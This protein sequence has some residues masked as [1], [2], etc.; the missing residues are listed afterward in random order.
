MVLLKTLNFWRPN[1]APKVLLGIILFGT[2]A[3]STSDVSR[4]TSISVGTGSPEFLSQTLDTE[5][6]ALLGVSQPSGSGL[7]SFR[8]SYKL[9]ANYGVSLRHSVSTGLSQKSKLRGSISGE[10]G[11][12]GYHLPDGV[13]LANGITRLTDPID[14][15]FEYIGLRPEIEVSRDVSLG[16][17]NVQFG[18]GAGYSMQSV[19]IK[20][21]S[22][23]LDFSRHRWSHTP[24]LLLSSRVPLRNESSEFEVYYR[25]SSAD[26][27][28][29][30]A[31]YT[32]SF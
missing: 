3:C 16:N 14:L 26:S 5:E 6:D 11:K 17:L 21:R 7:S 20:A 24:Y 18:V 25:R 28:N 12:L 8:P 2:A 22:A 32:H 29:F 15:T 10:I 30:S 4:T 27:E 9:S 19:T 23:L 31:A 13:L 1:R